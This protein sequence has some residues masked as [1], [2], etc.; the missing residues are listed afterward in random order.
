MS[1]KKVLYK[2]EVM[3]FHLKDTTVL[4]KCQQFKLDLTHEG[5]ILSILQMGTK[6]KGVK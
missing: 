1:R 3:I 6:L 2:S 4:K 5:G